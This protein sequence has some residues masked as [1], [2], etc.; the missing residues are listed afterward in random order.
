MPCFRLIAPM[1]SPL[2]STS[3]MVLSVDQARSCR[4]RRTEL[5]GMA[6]GPGGPWPDRAGRAGLTW[7][8]PEAEGWTH[9][10]EWA[11]LEIE[12]SGG[13]W[14]LA[15]TS[16]LLAMLKIAWGGMGG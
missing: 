10:F 9:V 12:C 6:G 11:Q 14:F 15:R 1:G 2:F 4:T 5:T 13:A 7:L 3:T 16:L 8:C